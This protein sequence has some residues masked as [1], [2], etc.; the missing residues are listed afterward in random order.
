VSASRA[1][2]ASAIA[3]GGALAAL[4]FGAAG[5]TSLGRTTT[6]EILV[7]LAAGAIVAL[8]ALRGLTRGPGGTVVVLFALFAGLTALSVT[9]SIVPAISYVEAGRTLTYLAIFTAAVAAAR[10]APRVPGVVLTG[11]AAAAV[12]AVGYALA[13]R[14]WPATLAENEL[15]NRIGA[16]FQYWNAVATTAALAVP[17]LLWLGSRRTGSGIGRALAYPA[18]GVCVLGMLL[19]QSRGAFAAAAIAVIAWFVF[20]PL[21][22]RSLPVLLVPVAAGSAVGAWALSKDAFSKTLQPLAARES[23]AGDFGLLLLL[24]LV[25]LLLVGVAVNMGLARVPTSMITRRRLGVAAAVIAVAAPLVAFTSVAMSDGG[26]GGSIS[27]RVDELVSET[28]TAPEQG[29]G[30]LTAASSTRG[31]YWRE[32]GR[33]LGDRPAL[34]VGAGAFEVARLRHRTDAAS[35]R[36]AH[37]YVMQTLADL[38]IAG[39]LLSLALL[40]AWL[41]AALRTTGLHPRTLPFR[42]REGPLPRRDWD[43]E[44]VAFVALALVAV[45]FG[46][47]SAI[48][49]TWFVPGPTAMALVAAGYVAGR[50][51][52]AALAVPGVGAVAQRRPPL[53]ASRVAAAAGVGLAAILVAWA[54]WQP[55]ASSNSVDR[56]LSLADQGRYEEAYEKT[57]DAADSDPLSP[58]PLMARA[59]VEAKAGLDRQAGRTLEQTVLKFPGDPD[60]WTELAR[61]Q[62]FTLDR[63]RRALETLRGAL[64]LDPYS[65]LAGALWLHARSAVRAAERERS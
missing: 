7:V 11:I 62:L 63:P 34:G 61:F 17:A 29:A 46:L 32:A 19:T 30:R 43:G 4:A 64:Y 2:A 13:S 45:A 59:Q 26:L 48:D 51:P 41:V 57:E 65:P 42:G 9:W 8:A 38:G 56:A 22:L 53:D 12:A 52:V 15:S 5:G 60:T 50:G 31:K 23:V 14:V 10:L 47:Q 58:A 54:I 36:H 3:L 37:G 27:D 44:R 35:T 21:R 18:M 25:L 49:W 24:M 40:G 33:V 6:T 16:P 1:S 55:E 20:V 28:D 39:L